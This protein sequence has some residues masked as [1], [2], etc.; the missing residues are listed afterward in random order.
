MAHAE[1]KPIPNTPITKPAISRPALKGS[2]D[3]SLI[4]TARKGQVR[5]DKNN[6]YVLH[7]AHQDMQNILLVANSTYKTSRY[8][9]EKQLSR[10][11]YIGEKKYVMREQRNIIVIANGRPQ[12]AKLVGY[13][14]TPSYTEWDLVVK[15]TDRLTPS[16][17]IG[18]SVMINTL[19]SSDVGLCEIELADS[20]KIT[21]SICS[22]GL[23]IGV[24]KF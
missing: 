13:R 18:V 3:W 6:H 16:V 14:R 12:S 24:N 19:P 8:I 4:F 15:N 11:H 5:Y 1:T 22:Y 10:I 21:A 7:I 17:S 9:D 20:K 23:V 2:S